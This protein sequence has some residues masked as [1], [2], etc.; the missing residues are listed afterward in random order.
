MD[1]EKIYAE[2]RE[3]GAT[4][5]EAERFCDIVAAEVAAE[6]ERLATLLRPLITKRQG[7]EQIREGIQAALRSNA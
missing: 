1:R 7:A 2:A 6:R 4:S 5:R 3:N